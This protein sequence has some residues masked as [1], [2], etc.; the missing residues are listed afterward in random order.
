MAT[1]TKILD[2]YGNPVDMRMLRE[3]QTSRIASLDNEYLTGMLEG[4]TPARL[5]DALREADAGNLFAQHRIFADMEERDAHLAAEMAKRKLA[6][7]DLEWSIE[8]PRNATAA[9]KA[10]AEWL[11]ETVSSAVDP[12]E[13]L[14]LALMDAVG[15]GFAPVELEWRSDHGEWLPAMHPRPQEWFCLNS[16]RRELRLRDLS[17][18][19]APLAPFGWIV[20]T[21]GKAKTGYLARMG[22]HRVLAWPFVYKTYA[23][24]DFA[25]LLETFGLPI[26]TGKYY[27]GADPEAKASLLRAV[28]AL[29][30]DARA[31]MPADMQI[32]IAKVSGG[33]DATPHMAMV[34]WAERSES[35]AILGQTMSAE[36]KATGIGSGNAQ[37]HREVREDILAADAREIAATITRD[38]LY[39][40][41]ALN[42]G[43]VDGLRRCPRLVFD[44]G[45]S[46]DIKQYA[47]ALPAL[48]NIGMQ[49][50]AD[51]AHDKL[52]I[53]RANNDEVVLR[54]QTGMGEDN[55]APQPTGSAAPSN[56]AKL[57][58][59][60]ALAPG[61]YNWH[62]AW[63]SCH[64]RALATARQL[65]R[66]LKSGEFDGLINAQT[67]L[68]D[69]LDRAIDAGIDW[70]AIVDPLLKPV[71]SALQN[72]MAP[73]EA[74]IEMAG[75]YPEMD[76]KALE[77]LFA[78]ALFVADIW[79]QL[80]AQDDDLPAP[81]E[82]R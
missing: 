63:A 78:R 37:L 34:D 29:G 43:G 53:P 62:Q 28:T 46:E 22:L 8:P 72:G 19:G 26:I 54:A 9:E 44:T 68:D 6:L 74:L 39:P 11:T 48:V 13:D 32:E 16:T 24:G 52:R 33:G 17:T 40:L 82:A 45:R 20:H 69:S 41:L 49:I 55:G 36:T 7:L 61:R 57:S 42:R 50:P 10:N 79:G 14:I 4:I 59:Q 47:E 18:D 21:H 2:Q 35:K 38:L 71:L 27:S 1:T 64:R 65:E 60:M 56:P 76:D 75:W 58:A 23:V 5:A 67:S 25:E 77:E 30:H 80:S 3:P 70:D 66:D 31:I 15:H 73:E 51:W 12:I 81:Q